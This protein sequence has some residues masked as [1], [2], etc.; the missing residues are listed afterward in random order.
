MH[1]LPKIEGPVDLAFM[2]S[3]DKKS[4]RDLF[5]LIWPRILPSGSVITDNA[6]THKE[7]LADFVGYV[8]RLHDAT[9]T[10]IS[11]GNGVEWTTKLP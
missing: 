11:I 1:V 9:S 6:T 3:G 2:D 5:D 10:E 4:T 7:E 8:R